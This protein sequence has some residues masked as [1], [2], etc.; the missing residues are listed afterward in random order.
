MCPS[1]RPP[2]GPSVWPHGCPMSESD[3]PGVEVGGVSHRYGSVSALGELTLAV[4]PG[5]TTA[6]AGPD[7]V[8]KST[9]LALIAGVKRLQAGTICTLGGSMASR[10]HRDAVAS[11]IAYMP[12]GLGRNLYPT[13]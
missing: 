4:P 1:W 10:A 8:G 6:F 2:S 11:R 12:Q 3:A 9:L 7:G 5:T 13:L